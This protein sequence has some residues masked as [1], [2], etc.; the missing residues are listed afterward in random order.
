MIAINLLWVIESVW[1]LVAGNVQPNTLGIAFVLFQAAVVALL[2]GLQILGVS[3]R[4]P[5]IA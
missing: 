2:A 3:R 1:L 5:A 4:S